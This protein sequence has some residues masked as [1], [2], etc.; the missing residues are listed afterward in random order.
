[1]YDLVLKELSAML[2]SGRPHGN[3]QPVYEATHIPVYARRDSRADAPILAQMVEALRLHRA[4]CWASPLT[5]LPSSGEECAA[6]AQRSRP[7]AR[8]LPA[9]QK[10]GNRI[11]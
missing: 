7:A 6:S 10:P 9:R 2:T 3:Q 5:C 4:V 8:V 1:M 11:K